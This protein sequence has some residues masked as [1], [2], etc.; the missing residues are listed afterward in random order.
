MRVRFFTDALGYGIVL[1]FRVFQDMQG[2]LATHQV[3]QP[4]GVVKAEGQQGAQHHGIGQVGKYG[5]GQ[6]GGLV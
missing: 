4:V 2:F 3:L 5:Q 1:N 6:R